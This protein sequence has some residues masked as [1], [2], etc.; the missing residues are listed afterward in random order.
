MESTVPGEVSDRNVFILGAGF[1]KS[2]GA[3]LID[4]FLDV[5]REIFDDPDS[6]LDHAEKKLFAQ[7]FEF[8]KRVAQSREK[9]RIDLDNIEQLFGLIEMSHRLEREE[10]VRNAMVYVIAKTLQLAIAKTRQRQA[11]RVSAATGFYS[12]N[13]S[14]ADRVPR[15]NP[16]VL[17][18]DIYSHFALLLSGLYDPPNKSRS[19][20]VIT[21]NY[22]LVLDDALRGIGVEPLYG[23]PDCALDELA[24]PPG[25]GV[26]VL[27]LHG[28]TN[29]AICP[30][31]NK[32]H[33]LGVKFTGDPE[34][35]RTRPCA[36]CGKP[37]LNLLLVPPSWDKSEYRE[38]M[39]PVWNQAVNA[40]K[41][42]KRI[43]VIGYS[44][45]ET[46]TFFKFL[47]AL[48]L[49][50]N[51]QLYRFV[52][53]D[54]INRSLA[55]EAP[56]EPEPSTVIEAR[57]KAMFETLFVKRRFK[58]FGD[59]SSNFLLSVGSAMGRAETISAHGIVMAP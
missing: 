56:P 3:P 25:T 57:Y 51:H 46:D 27:K 37:G 45:P 1:S 44:M 15:E 17:T 29:W 38:T 28:S 7:V 14:W 11:V 31:C 35:F 21:F 42:A 32:V 53:V 13:F 43:C 30:Q 47:L 22:D 5:S 33:V 19:N 49:A 55:G 52:L 39:R 40:L 59:G 24:V 9:F 12:T 58:F 54:K 41:T 8:K 23:L 20:V 2:A 18:P 16:N 34:A 4:E 48:G 50:E 6:G 36:K 10:D 26:S